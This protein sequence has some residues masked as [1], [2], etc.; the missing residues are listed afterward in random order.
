MN[1]DVKDHRLRQNYIL[2]LDGEEE[3]AVDLVPVGKVKNGVTEIQGDH[4]DLLVEHL[5][6]FGYKA[7]KAGG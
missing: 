3:F 4:R 2:G 5:N 1:V 6:L 7:V